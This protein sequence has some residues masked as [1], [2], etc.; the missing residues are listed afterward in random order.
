MD[1]AIVGATGL[2]GQVIFE[3]LDK[4]KIKV[5]NIYAVASERSIGQSIKFKGADIKIISI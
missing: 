2:V 3:I 4:S 5:D 1:V